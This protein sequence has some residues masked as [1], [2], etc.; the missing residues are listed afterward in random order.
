MKKGT[1]MIFLVSVAFLEGVWGKAADHT[2]GRLSWAAPHPL[3]HHPSPLQP[4]ATL[5]CILCGSPQTSQ[6]VIDPVLYLIVQGV[7]H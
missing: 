1:K 6:C 7:P 3:C 4:L 5:C 2:W